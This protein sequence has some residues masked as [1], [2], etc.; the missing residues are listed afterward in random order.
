[1]PPD[2]EQIAAAIAALVA[3]ENE[4]VDAIRKADLRLNRVRAARTALEALSSEEPI[5]F[6]GRLADACREVLKRAAG[7]SLSPV[8]IRDQLKVI[9]YDISTNNHTNI[10]ASVHSVLKR[11]AGPDKD[12]RQKQAKDGSGARYWW[13]GERQ[14]VSGSN[15]SGGRLADLVLSADAA[16][17]FNR[18]SMAIDQAL[19]SSAMIDTAHE[20]EQQ[21]EK[22]AKAVEHMD[23]ASLLKKRK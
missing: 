15:L 16:V 3:Q 2:D 1:M 17:E 13:A 23:I 19:K 8:E 11:M 9:G 12:V 20:I 4:L 10:M 5:E 21:I 14:R 6:E 22:A 7:N 18:T